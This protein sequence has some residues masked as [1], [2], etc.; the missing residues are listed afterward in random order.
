MQ[1]EFRKVE[2]KDSDLNRLLFIRDGKIV[3]EATNEE[4]EGCYQASLN[5]ILGFV[6]GSVSSPEEKFSTQF[7]SQ[8][9]NDELRVDVE[10]K[11]IDSF[12]FNRIIEEA[13]RPPVQHTGSG[14]IA[15]IEEMLMQLL[16]GEKS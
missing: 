5:C 4:T 6:I 3:F 16:S 13:K 15:E 12:Q 14:N 8:P 1:F 10:H 11:D 9:L 7:T 2:A